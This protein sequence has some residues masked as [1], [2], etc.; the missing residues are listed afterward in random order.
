LF[1]QHQKLTLL[2]FSSFFSSLFKINNNQNE[3]HF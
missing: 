3:R 1:H 2:I